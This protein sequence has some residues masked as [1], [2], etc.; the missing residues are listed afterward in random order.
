M[1]L[2]ECYRLCK[3]Y[4]E[5]RGSGKLTTYDYLFEDADSE[6]N[7]GNKN[8]ELVLVGIFDNL[9]KYVQSG[10]PI[11]VTR[12]VLTKIKLKHHRRNGVAFISMVLSN[13]IFATRY[14]KGLINFYT[15]RTDEQGRTGYYQVGISV[16]DKLVTTAYPISKSAYNTALAKC[17]K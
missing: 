4:E 11:Y 1:T 14:K 12:G 6:Q 5:L 3:E 9:K 2:L 16:K 17:L 15:T 13:F 10:G 8:Q 7:A